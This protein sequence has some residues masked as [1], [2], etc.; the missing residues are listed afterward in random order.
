MDDSDRE[1]D[2]RDLP[3]RLDA[4]SLAKWRKE[5]R[6][7][8]RR[9]ARP[10]TGHNAERQAL[11]DLVA[12]LRRKG[13]LRRRRDPGEVEIIAPGVARIVGGL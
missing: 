5:R 4:A 13:R 10:R 6:E 9:P 2:A 12:L 7:P 1:P 3:K 8:P 11:R